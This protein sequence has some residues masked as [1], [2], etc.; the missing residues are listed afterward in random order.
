[1]CRQKKQAA[2]KVAY[3]KM[4]SDLNAFKATIN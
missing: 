1:M 2:A 3:A 4:M